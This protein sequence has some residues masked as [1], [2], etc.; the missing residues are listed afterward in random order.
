MIED[1]VQSLIKGQIN[2]TRKLAPWEPAVRRAMFVLTNQPDM[3][4]RSWP[5]ER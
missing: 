3:A 4:A 2:V 1:I 5:V